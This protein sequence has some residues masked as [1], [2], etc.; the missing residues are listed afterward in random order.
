M[1]GLLTEAEAA[2]LIDSFATPVT[3]IR[4]TGSWNQYGEWQQVGQPTS[5]RV[6]IASASQ[7]G[8]MMTGSGDQDRILDLASLAM[9]QRAFY[10]AKRGSFVSNPPTF[11]TETRA[12]DV[13]VYEEKRYRVMRIRGNYP[14]AGFWEI[15]GEAD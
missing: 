2:S 10:V 12:P 3:Y 4:T 13:I 6:N 15:I 14:E 7:V 11:G 9:N 5:E 1:D 8:Q